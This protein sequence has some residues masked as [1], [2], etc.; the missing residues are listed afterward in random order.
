MIG[1]RLAVYDNVSTGEPVCAPILVSL[2]MF[3]GNVC[4]CIHIHIY[5]IWKR[6]TVKGDAESYLMCCLL[7]R[8]VSKKG[9][10]LPKLI[11][12]HKTDGEKD[13]HVLAGAVCLD[14]KSI[15]RMALAS[16]DVDRNIHLFLLSLLHRCIS[17]S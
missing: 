13:G 15:N 14:Y 10:C 16:P 17:H 12:A 1:L 4:T 8:R 2:C 11:M 7:L 9:C 5:G 3:F 6:I